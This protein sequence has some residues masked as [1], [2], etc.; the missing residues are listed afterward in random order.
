MHQYFC[1]FVQNSLYVE[2]VFFSNILLEAKVNV[3]NPAK[4][5]AR[6]EHSTR[7]Q[8]IEKLYN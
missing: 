7:N 1:S 4:N 3:L 8:F 6:Y 5:Y 2:E